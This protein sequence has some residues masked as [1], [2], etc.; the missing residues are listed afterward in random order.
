[1]QNWHMGTDRLTEQKSPYPLY[2]LY[3]IPC[4]LSMQKKNSPE[5]I[6][7]TVLQICTY[8]EIPNSDFGIL[9]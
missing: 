3:H 8:T 4:P 6:S 9:N 7:R 1:M 5:K 2:H